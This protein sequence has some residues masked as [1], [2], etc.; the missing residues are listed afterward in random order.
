VKSIEQIGRV[1]GMGVTMAVAVLSHT[2][3]RQPSAVPAASASPRQRVSIVQLPLRFEQNRGQFDRSARYVARQGG[4][5]FFATDEGATLALRGAGGQTAALRLKVHGGRPVTPRA[6]RPLAT[7]S[8]YF[9]GRDPARWRT[10]VPNFGEIVYPEARPGV[11]LVFHGSAAG[12]LEYDLI[13]APGTSPDVALDVEGADRVRVADDGSLEVMLGERVLRQPPPRVYQIVDGRQR[14]LRGRYRLVG[15]ATVAFAV[16]DYD[17]ARPLVI[18]PVLLYGTFLGGASDELPAGVWVDDSGAIYVAGTTT[19]IDFPLA[20][21]KQA[22]YKGQQDIFAV[23]FT[24][25]GDALVYAT[26]LGGT[27]EE[28]GGTIAVDGTGA[29]YVVGTTQSDDFPVV[30]ALQATNAT[31]NDGFI[32]KLSPAGD[33]LVFSTFLGGGGPDEIDGLAVDAAGAVYVTGRTSSSN[34]PVKNA[35][36]NTMKG[37]N[38]L[39]VAKLDPTGAS[40]VYSTYLGGSAGEDAGSIA[41]DATGAAYVTGDTASNDFPTVTPIQAKFG[42]GNVDAIV[43][44]LT[45]TGDA[46]S[47]S[48]YLGGNDDDYVGRLAVD[49]SGAV[50][51]V[52]STLSFDFPVTN[53]LQAKHANTSAYDGIVAKLMPTGTALAFSTYLGGKGGD[54]LNG[55]EL[56]G[57]GTVYLSGVSNSPDFPIMDASQPALAGDFDGVVVAMTTSGDAITSSTYLGG[58]AED[59]V[60]NLAL[61][62]GGIVT[63]IGTTLSHD[64]PVA[65]G[66]QNQLDGHSDGFVA[67]LGG[68]LT[69]VPATATLAPGAALTFTATGG[70]GRY[71]WSLATNGSAAT[72]DAASGAYVAGAIEGTDV[73]HVVDWLGDHADATV[74]VTTSPPA[75]GDLG[76]GVATVPHGGCGCDISGRR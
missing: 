17:R 75:G 25:A 43:A 16:A 8:N 5:T 28:Q 22:I 42:G 40:L 4:L 19:S 41:V 23:K 69:I 68:A 76:G 62:P 27:L 50:Y 14:V 54:Q 63:V 15:A 52:G 59:V 45:P 66:L 10:G 12:R 30:N 64:F 53:A 18:D 48:T 11:D 71:A 13:V 1:F 60:V 24:P 33:A 49:A 44:K 26:Y 56:D 72:I 3:C 61:G 35:L 21:Q 37:L 65:R 39:F 29:L 2:G 51:V 67:R 73:V 38:D 47:W 74:T 57:S 55:V 9:L 58:T 6:R 7:R 20:S 46:L 32:T 36:Q 34:F 31:E 70:G